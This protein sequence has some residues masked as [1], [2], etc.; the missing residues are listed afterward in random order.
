MLRRDYAN[1]HQLSPESFEI[2]ICDRLDKMGLDVARVGS[3]YK[4][5]GGVDI[6]AWPRKPAPF[7]FLLATQVKHHMRPSKKTGP[8][9]VKDLQAV[10]A[11][12]PFHAGLLVTSTS[13]TPSAHW[14]AANH[15]H[16]I[17]LRDMKDLQR[18]IW[19]NFTDDEEWREI[20]SS[21]ELAPG[22]NIKI[23]S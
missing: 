6:V 19:N 16:I 21:I 11:S 10:I 15:P 20:P 17:R 18:W 9:A 13:F 4:P 7:P 3:T 2:F 14:F 22:V 12:K 8:D 23:D 5:D 1:I